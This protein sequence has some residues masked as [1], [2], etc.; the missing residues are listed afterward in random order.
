[1]DRIE[2]LR[3]VP[4]LGNT[5]PAFLEKLSGRTRVVEF[6]PEAR[7]VE[8]GDPGDALYILVEGK[9]QVLYPGRSDD[10]ELARLGPGEF[11]GEMALLNRKPRSATIRALTPVQ[12]LAL[13]RDDF[14]DVLIEAP[15]I[16]IGLLEILSNR[17]RNADEQISGLSEEALRDPLTSL[18]NRR[19]FHERLREEVER[20]ARYDDVFSLILLDV[21]HF[22]TV[23][24]SFGH[25]AGDRVLAWIGRLL[26]EHT[27]TADV[28]FRIGG[29]EFAVLAPATSGEEAEHAARRLVQVVDEARPPLEAEVRLTLSGGFASCP[30]DGK[31]GAALY[32]A[33]DHALLRAKAEGRNRVLSPL[34]AG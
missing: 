15:R 29:E 16:G 7:I 4:L 14:R 26:T 21:D 10:F 1:M 27:R 25:E 3:K 22:D 8:L 33:A 30:S 2:L 31:N 24:D 6:A 23:N 28:P 17:I 5:E 20:Q 32:A 34:P 13:G 9:V 18:L 11:F 12:A 19:A